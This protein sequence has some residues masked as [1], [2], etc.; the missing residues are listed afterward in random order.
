MP[1]ITPIDWKTP[2]CIFIKAGF[3][4][5]GQ[6]GSHRRYLKAG[7]SRPV[8]IPAYSEISKDIVMANIRTAGMSRDEYFKYLGE[9]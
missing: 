3:A 1:R 9:C 2:E 7:C 6:T 4:F 5:Q 8:I